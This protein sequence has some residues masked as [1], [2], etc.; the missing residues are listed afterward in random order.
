[1]GETH[2]TKIH[3]TESSKIFEEAWVE[4]EHVFCSGEALKGHPG[5]YLHIGKE[6]HV[7]CPYCSKCFRQKT[8]S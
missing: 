1:M 8:H 5:V 3:T 4:E 6:G 2:K 7:V